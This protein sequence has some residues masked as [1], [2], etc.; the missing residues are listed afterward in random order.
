M[1]YLKDGLFTGSH[2]V[3][4]QKINEKNIVRMSDY[5]SLVSS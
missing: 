3:M 5:T 2:F 1:I 4:P